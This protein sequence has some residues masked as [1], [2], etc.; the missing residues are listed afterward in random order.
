[1]DGSDL[2]LWKVIVLGAFIMG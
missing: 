1:M 2:V